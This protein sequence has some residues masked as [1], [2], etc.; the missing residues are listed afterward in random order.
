MKEK[1]VFIGEDGRERIYF[2]RDTKGEI[3]FL[4]SSE[5]ATSYERM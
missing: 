5:D 3:K 4:V 2:G 1:D